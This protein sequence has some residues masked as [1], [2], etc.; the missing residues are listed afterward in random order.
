[1]HFVLSPSSKPHFTMP[2]CPKR[3]SW[4]YHAEWVHVHLDEVVVV[5]DGWEIFLCLQYK[6]MCFDLA[7]SHRRRRCRQHLKLR[8]ILSFLYPWDF[9]SWPQW[10]GKIVYMRQRRQE[11]SVRADIEWEIS[12]TSTPV[13][14]LCGLILGVVKEGVFVTALFVTFYDV[15]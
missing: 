15:G 3:L 11:T 2:G 14:S 7:D 6:G 8:G 4:V 9:F 10:N 12:S 5:F 13:T 1:M